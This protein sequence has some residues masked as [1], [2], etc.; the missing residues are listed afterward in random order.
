MAPN[1]A[2]LQALARQ[3]AAG[4]TPTGLK[5]L[6]KPK[7]IQ[8]I[9][10]EQLAGAAQAQYPNVWRPQSLVGADLDAYAGF[11]L[12]PNYPTIKNKIIKTA[13]PAWFAASKST[14][15]TEQKIVAAIQK[16][17]SLAEIKQAI[18]QDYEDDKLDFPATN[19]SADPLSAASAYAED[20]FKEYNSKVE[21]AVK[22]YLTTSDKTFKANLPHPNLKYGPRTNLSKGIIGVDT[23]NDSVKSFID[24]KMKEYSGM[25]QNL[26]G[27]T[28]SGYL[29]PTEHV[30]AVVNQKRQTPFKDEAIRRQSLKNKNIKP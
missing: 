22:D 14:N 26:P 19:A 23:I 7:D 27:F 8:D 25:R 16:G 12:G 20:L 9:F 15:P 10:D 3:K 2:M 17:Y 1:Q 4:K 28:P 30:V 29:D 5:S 6:A 21:P 11:I 24:T 18:V 13:A